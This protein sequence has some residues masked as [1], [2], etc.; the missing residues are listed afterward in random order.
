[1]TTRLTAESPSRSE[2]DALRSEVQAIGRVVN[3]IGIMLTTRADGRP[4]KSSQ[5]RARRYKVTKF[6]FAPSGQKTEEKVFESVPDVA[7]F[8]GYAPNTVSA[9]LSD[10]RGTW[11][12]NA[13]RDGT[14][15][16]VERLS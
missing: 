15:F 13:R 7:E 4:K 14:F 12:T 1:M 10:G 3:E 16:V 5:T 11:R 9:R 6:T 2:F 8:T